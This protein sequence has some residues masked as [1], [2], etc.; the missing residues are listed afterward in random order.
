MIEPRRLARLVAATALR[1]WALVLPMPLRYSA[2]YFWMVSAN[3]GS[4]ALSFASAPGWASSASRVFIQSRAAG[5]R[6]KVSVSL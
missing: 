1:T 5:S 3:V 4:G 2:T 6:S